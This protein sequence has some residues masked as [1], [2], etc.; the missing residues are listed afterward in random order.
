MKK[1]TKI[2]T[3][4][5]ILNLLGCSLN[6]PTE[7][8]IENPV[9]PPPDSEYQTSTYENKEFGLRFEYPSEWTL[10]ESIGGS[11]DSNSLDIH[12]S[13]LTPVG[14]APGCQD[15]YAG[16][17][18]QSTQVQPSEYLG[19][20]KLAKTVLLCEDPSS[21]GLGCI[22]GDIETITINNLKGYKGTH[23]GWDGC[24]GP[25]YA[26]EQDKNQ[27]IY[28][29]TG[30]KEASASDKKKIDNT[31]NSIASVDK[32]TSFCDKAPTA[33][34]IGRNILPIELEY[35]TIEF[36]GQI[37]TAYPCGKD[38]ISQ[39][40]GVEGDSYTLGST[41]FLKQK[42]SQP[43]SDVLK[44]IGFSCKSETESECKE[45]T[46]KNTVKIDDIMKLKPYAD[47]IEKDDCVNCG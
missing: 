33:T 38:R 7:D 36:L 21:Q 11:P 8:P 27:Y 44:E 20:E 46:L 26:L 19:F 39:I 45:W 30:T 25:G 28:I 31:I 41:I 47:Q 37:F 2:V 22:S 35:K 17:E 18:I 6:P 1:I 16:I 32:E 43:F 29:F 40:F 24:D 3:T 23:S 34:D 42:A 12:L 14:D 4:L 13:N 9:I 15:G 5:A 10:D